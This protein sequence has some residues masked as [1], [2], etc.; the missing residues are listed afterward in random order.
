ME[1]IQNQAL[2]EEK[3]SKKNSKILY[4]IFVPIDRKSI[5]FLFNFMAKNFPKQ[6]TA[7]SKPVKKLF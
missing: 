3:V 7:N 2:L 1:N 4:L 6:V 5:Y